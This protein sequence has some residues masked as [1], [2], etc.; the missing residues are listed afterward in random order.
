[1]QSGSRG[2]V[3]WKDSSATWAEYGNPHSTMGNGRID[4]VQADFLIVGKQVLDW[5]P[6][7]SVCFHHI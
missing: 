6:D 1:M 3:A 4:T 2:A 7:S 5:I